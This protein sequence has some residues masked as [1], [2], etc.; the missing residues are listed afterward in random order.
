MLDKR[1]LHRIKSLVGL[2]ILA[3]GL[4]A[5]AGMRQNSLTDP[6]ETY[7]QV[8]KR[9]R[10]W[11]YTRVIKGIPTDEICQRGDYVRYSPEPGSRNV[12]R[13]IPPYVMALFGT[14]EQLD[15]RGGQISQH[16][17]SYAP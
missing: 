15:G 8:T 12:Y 17:S 9:G 14:M 2:A 13:P 16:V 6:D 10:T 5:C 3:S 7:M 1:L 11:C 4:T